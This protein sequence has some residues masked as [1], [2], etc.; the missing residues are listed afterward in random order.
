MRV[1]L[2]VQSILTRYREASRTFGHS[3]VT[4]LVALVLLSLLLLWVIGELFFAVCLSMMA[5]I[6][7][8]LTGAGRLLRRL[9]RRAA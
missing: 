3:A 4:A 2:V 7:G 5:L 1:S 9:K 8:S 6:M